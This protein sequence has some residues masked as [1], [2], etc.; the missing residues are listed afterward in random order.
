MKQKYHFYFGAIFAR[1]ET[2]PLWAQNTPKVVW[3][4]IGNLS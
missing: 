4:R 3:F 1:Y 2:K